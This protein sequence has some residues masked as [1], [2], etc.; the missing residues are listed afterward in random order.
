MRVA[1]CLCLLIVSALAFAQEPAR[2]RQ[3]PMLKAL[4]SKILVADDVSPLPRRVTVTYKT[5][6]IMAGT[7]AAEE[8]SAL[9]I[10]CDL[11]RLAIPR[12]RIA[13]IA[14]DVDAA[15]RIPIVEDPSRK[16]Q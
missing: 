6:V 9:V 7:I 16:D 5:G 1:T 8:P 13:T 14:Y 12:A 10:D 2:A 4:P 11:G 15:P 3:R